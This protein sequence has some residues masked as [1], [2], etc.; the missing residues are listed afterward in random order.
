[1]FGTADRPPDAHVTLTHIVVDVLE[2]AATMGDLHHALAAG[3]VRRSDVHA[4]LGEVV[5]GKKI[6]RRASTERIVFDS[7]GMALQ[8]V[9]AAAA[10]YERAVAAGR[11]L[12]VALGA[13][14][15]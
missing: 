1:M 8:D 7:T 10:V 11:G 4:E 5:A 2:Q 14:G 9:A 13:E 6:G 12:R 15:A 3:I